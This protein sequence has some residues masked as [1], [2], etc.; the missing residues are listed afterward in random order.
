MCTSMINSST[1]TAVADDSI[2]RFL[3]PLLACLLACVPAAASCSVFV[4]PPLTKACFAILSA[5]SGSKFPMDSA[6]DGVWETTDVEEALWREG[7]GRAREEE[8]EEVE[9]FPRDCVVLLPMLVLALATAED[10]G[11]LGWRDTVTLKDD[12]PS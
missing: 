10:D 8:E 3:E 9:A 2:P 11:L 6:K 5:L 1:K 7:D 12:M 4:W